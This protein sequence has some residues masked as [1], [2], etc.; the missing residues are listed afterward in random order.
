[1]DTPLSRV[2]AEFK[3]TAAL[4]QRYVQKYSVQGWTPYYGFPSWVRLQQTSQKPK[5][6]KDLIQIY[7]K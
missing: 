2:R 1:M 6:V 5:N 4:R 3:K 7:T